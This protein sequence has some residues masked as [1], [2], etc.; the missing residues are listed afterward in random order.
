MEKVVPEAMV[1]VQLED[2]I[3]DKVGIEVMIVGSLVIERGTV[4]RTVVIVERV[5]H[6]IEVEIEAVVGFP[7]DVNHLTKS[8]RIF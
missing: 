3:L 2:M 1:A 6:V 8:R 5:A 4:E 7:L